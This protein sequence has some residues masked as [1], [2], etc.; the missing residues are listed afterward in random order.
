MNNNLGKQINTKQFVALTHSI[1]GSH[2][3]SLLDP[4]HNQRGACGQESSLPG[5]VRLG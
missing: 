2:I 1:H 5:T 4:T 3:V